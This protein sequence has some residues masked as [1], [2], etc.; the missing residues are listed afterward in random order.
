MLLVE[1]RSPSTDAVEALG[2]GA[3]V[4]EVEVF[5]DIIREHRAVASEVDLGRGRLILSGDV[6]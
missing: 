3:A 1:F 5:R 2:S 4:V 6:I